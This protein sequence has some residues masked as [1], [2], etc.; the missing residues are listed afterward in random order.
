MQ[1]LNSPN[2]ERDYDRTSL[3]Y[4]FEKL[5]ML[6]VYLEVLEVQ[7]RRYARVKMRLPNIASQVSHWLVTF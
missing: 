7:Y 5:A 2:F 4:A 6:P 3:L 1:C